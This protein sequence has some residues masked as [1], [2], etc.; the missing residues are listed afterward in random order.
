[1]QVI[2]Y[3]K[4]EIPGT[5]LYDLNL[6]EFSTGNLANSKSLLIYGYRF[7]EKG[8]FVSKRRS[9]LNYKYLNVTMPT[10]YTQKDFIHDSIKALMKFMAF[11]DIHASG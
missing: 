3:L 1:M 4:S 9:N 6:E 7:L 5:N 8:G 2:S 10:E 11:V